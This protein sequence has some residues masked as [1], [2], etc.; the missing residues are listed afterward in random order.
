MRSEPAPSGIPAAARASPPVAACAALFL[1]AALPLVA[2]PLPAR[3]QRAL[4]L[5]VGAWAV[6]G[7]DPAL[8]SAALR[9]PLLGPFEGSLETFGLVDRAPAGRSLYGVGPELTAILSRRRLR[10]YLVAGTGVALELGPSTDVAAVWSAGAGL[11]LRL[12]PWMGVRA[13]VRRFV[14]DRHFGG[15]WN[16]R[17]DDRMGWQLSA[18]LSIRWG[19][20]PGGGATRGR[21]GGRGTAGAGDA[22]RPPD[23]RVPAGADVASLRA[24]VVD[25]ALAMMGEPY[26]WGGSSA[27]RGF[28]CSGLVWY[29]Y[30]AHGIDI[31]RVSRD[32]ARIGS[33]VPAD[34]SGLREGDILLFSDDPPRVTHVGLYIGDGRFIHS[35]SSGGV[36]IGS[37]DPGS[38][39]YEAWWMDRWVGA[40]GVLGG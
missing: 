15:F 18:G 2:V 34:V 10:P 5:D 30:G 38:E 27:A 35:T 23:G 13:E 17:A 12:F 6:L 39:A 19:G 24:S 33:P 1:G 7:S 37:L 9:R 32:Q 29:A 16:L 22:G 31:P 14:E 20:G 25:T 4:D 11:D 36:E 21:P 28:D 3:A 26:R 8:Y 40:R